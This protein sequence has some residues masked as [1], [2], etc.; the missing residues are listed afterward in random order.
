TEAVV[1]KIVTNAQKLQLLGI[2][3]AV[4]IEVVDLPLPQFVGLDQGEGRTLHRAGVPRRTDKAAAERGLA[5][6]QI[7]AQPDTAAPLQRS[8]DLRSQALHGLIT[9]Y[10]PF[11]AH[12]QLLRSRYSRLCST[13]ALASMPSSPWSQAARSPARACPST[14]RRAAS[15]A[16]MRCASSAPTS[17]DSTS[18]IPAVAIPGLPWLHRPGSRSPAASATSEPTPL[19]TA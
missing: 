7:S 16:A 10:M 5:G 4:K 8:A 6:A 3:Q 9:Q 18:P 15:G 17:P 12:L 11:Q 13:R 1:G 19:R 14:A 2:G